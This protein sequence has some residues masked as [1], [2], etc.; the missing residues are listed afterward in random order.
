MRFEILD[1]RFER[2]KKTQY[3]PRRHGD[4]DGSTEL[5]LNLLK[6]SPCLSKGLCV[7]AAS[8]VEKFFKL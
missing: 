2:P 1:F 4:A 7:F 8:A 3:E 6:D 5:V